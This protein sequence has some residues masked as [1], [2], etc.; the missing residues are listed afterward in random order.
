MY[1]YTSLYH[2]DS[3][4]PRSKIS[5][6]NISSGKVLRYLLIILVLYMCVN[7]LIVNTLSDS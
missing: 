5:M 1:S 7:L 4:V 3:V 6:S 2:A